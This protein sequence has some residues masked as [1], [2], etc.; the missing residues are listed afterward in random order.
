MHNGLRKLTAS[1]LSYT[2]KGKFCDS[3]KNVTVT[4][5]Q[6]FLESTIMSHT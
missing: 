5:L 2:E 6:H 4:G 3:W 1:N